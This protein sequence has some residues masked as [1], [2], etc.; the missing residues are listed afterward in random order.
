[1][2][3]PPKPLN[4]LALGSEVGLEITRDQ[5]GRL[6]ALAAWLAERAFPLG[7]TNYAS[8]SDVAARAIAP[9]FALFHLLRPPPCG[10]AVD[11]GA[12]SGALGLTLAVLSPALRVTLADRRRKAAA[13]ARLTASHLGLD[14]VE[15]RQVTAEKLAE[16]DPQAFHLVCIRALAKA[17]RALRL[18]APLLAPGGS[19]AV[20][21]RSG[22]AGYAS[23]DE[24]WC[25]LGT[26]ETTV[27]GLSVSRLRLA[28]DALLPSEVTP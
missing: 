28:R 16:T 12:G 6:E 19:V 21:H 17:Q 18:A 7:L 23:P 11:L 27:P 4:W 2:T 13:F 9:A 15:V 25:L 24:G 3:A 5:A 14:F 8:P 26:A 1:M 10:R 20:W 22:D